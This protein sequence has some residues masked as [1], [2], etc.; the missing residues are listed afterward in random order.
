MDK[1]ILPTAYRSVRYIKGSNETYKLCGSSFIIER[2]NGPLL[3]K[4]LHQLETRRRESLRQ[5]MGTSLASLHTLGI[6]H[7]DIKDNNIMFRTPEKADCVFIDSRYAFPGVS[8]ACV[9]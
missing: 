6:G 2:M 8:F 4:A 9:N 7:G 5:E 3:G 1:F